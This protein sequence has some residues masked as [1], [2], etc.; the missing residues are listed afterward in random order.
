MAGH[1][2]RK[3]SGKEGK[4]RGAH[5]IRGGVAGKGE[6]RAGERVGWREEWDGDAAG[7][8]VNSVRNGVRKVI[9]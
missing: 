8:R 5:W 1:D 2:E 4:E 7:R 9:L 3:R 6:G